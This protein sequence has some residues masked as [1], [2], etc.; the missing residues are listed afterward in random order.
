[1]LCDASQHL[2]ANLFTIVKCKHIIGESRTA[3]RSVSLI[4][5]PSWNKAERTC[6]AL[7]EGH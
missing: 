5:Q 6:F 4:S 2:G 1:M 7:A 3:K